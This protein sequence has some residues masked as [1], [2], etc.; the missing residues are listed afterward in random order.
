MLIILLN[1][2][3]HTYHRT[4]L[5]FV[6]L[7]RLDLPPL[8]EPS[9]GHSP[10]SI[11]KIWNLWHK[12][13]EVKNWNLVNVAINIISIIHFHQYPFKI[14]SP[15]LLSKKSVPYILLTNILPANILQ[16]ILARSLLP[17]IIQASPLVSQSQLTRQWRRTPR[18]IISAA[19]S[20]LS[21]ITLFR[22]NITFSICAQQNNVKLR[23]LQC[24]MLAKLSTAQWAVCS[25]LFNFTQN[26][27]SICNLCVR[28]ICAQIPLVDLCRTHKKELAI[29]VAQ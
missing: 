12:Y 10:W 24:W 15:I 14:S 7:P 19:Y 22:V 20:V 18:K 25:V 9:P 27:G 13:W 5:P 8:P 26:L 21:D 1:T 2:S 11:W 4:D 23:R 3:Y 28:S 29:A 16:N 17:Y 6:Y